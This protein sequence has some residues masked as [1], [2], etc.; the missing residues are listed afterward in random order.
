MPFSGP[1]RPAGPGRTVVMKKEALLYEKLENN[2]VRCLLCAHNC[3]IDDSRYGFCGVRK[4]EKGVLYTCVY[5][6][7]AAAHV[8]P[9]EKKPFY[10]FLPGTNAFSV[11]T[12]GCNFRCPFCQN[13][14]I[15]QQSKKNGFSAG[16]GLTPEEIVRQAKRN[17][18]KSISYT[19]T[20][21]TVFFEYAYDTSKLA[22]QE[23]IF[24]TFVTNGYMTGKALK[25]IKP[26]LDACNVDLKFFNEKMYKRICEASLKPVLESI[27]LMKKLG[28]WVEITTLVVPGLNDSDKELKGIAGFIKSVDAAIPWHVSRFHPDYQFTD[29]KETPLESLRK[30]ESIGKAAGLKYIYP[31]NV[32]EEI[33]T[34]CH[35]CGHKLIVRAGYAVEENNIKNGKCPAC[36]TAVEGVW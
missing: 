15:S 18:C 14:Q 12:A 33:D 17:K 3:E 4:N 5:A 9:I 6:E 19:Y 11:A 20:E 36:N 2:R 21:P 10:H 27:R 35:E 1:I 24:N 32:A 30:A 25:K 16:V 7:A 13:W 22:G 28:M 34:V 29:T 26:Y 8:D 23:G 31:G